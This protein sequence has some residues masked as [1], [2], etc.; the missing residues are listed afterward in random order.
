MRARPDGF[1]LTFTHPVDA[2][3][4]SDPASYKMREFTYIYR[5]KYGSPEVDEVIPRSPP[6]FRRGWAE[7]CGSSSRL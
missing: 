7:A 3:T 6:P 5:S 1:E 4:A 2:K